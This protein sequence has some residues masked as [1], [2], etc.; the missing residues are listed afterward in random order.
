[1]SSTQKEG[2]IKGYFK[3]FAVLKET[4]REY[5]G[6]QIVNFL[7]MTAYFALYGI[8]VIFLSEDFGFSDVDARAISTRPSR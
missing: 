6:L 4:K 3:G 8:V 1:M 7:D 2:F 5:W